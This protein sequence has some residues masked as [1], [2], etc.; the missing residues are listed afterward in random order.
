[1]D[2]KIQADHVLQET[3]TKL[4]YEWFDPDQLADRINLDGEWLT[5][6]VDWWHA[7]EIRR[8]VHTVTTWPL[9]A[10]AQAESDT[11]EK[12]LTDLN[13]LL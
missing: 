1:M 4:H 10:G 5:V 12:G 3:S 11:V 13:V 8:V 7:E 6:D 2:I 9:D